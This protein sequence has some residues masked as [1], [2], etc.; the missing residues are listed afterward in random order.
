MVGFLARYPRWV[1]PIFA[2]RPFNVTNFS[3]KF[4]HPN[5]L[6]WYNACKNHI[7]SMYTRHFNR[8][9]RE[10]FIIFY[11]Y[12]Y[13]WATGWTARI[14][15]PVSSKVNGRIF[16]PLPKRVGPPFLLSGHLREDKGIY[17][18]ILKNIIFLLTKMMSFWEMI[19]LESLSLASHFDLPLPISIFVISGLFVFNAL[20]LNVCQLAHFLFAWR[21]SQPL[22]RTT[23]SRI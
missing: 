12:F 6:N 7:L 18:Y 5:L 22:S 8:H 10:N 3:S 16:D 21:N 2:I 4:S 1:G 13:G 9:V 23:L 15:P 20:S 14:C 19:F 17:I 11:M